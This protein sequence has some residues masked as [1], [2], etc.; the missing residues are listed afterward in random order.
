MR[1]RQLFHRFVFVALLAAL[2]TG[3]VP[4][5]SGAQQ[6]AGR[7]SIVSTGGLDFERQ[8]VGTYGDFQTITIRNDNETGGPIV[9]SDLDLS[10]S[11][12]DDFLGSTNC[13]AGGGTLLVGQSCQIRI[14]FAPL[15]VGPRSV[16]L[17]INHAVL[18]SPVLLEGEGTAGYY[19]A[20]RAGQVGEFGDA[21]WYGDAA[22][23]RLNAPMIS[24]ATTANGGGYWLLGRDGGIFSYGNA[25]F[26]GSTGGMRLNKP[27]V[28]MA[29]T[30]TGKGYWLV[31]SDGGIFA[32]G[33]ARFF[34]S[35]GSLR[36]NKP[37]V[38]M[39]A[40][41]TGKGYWLVASDGGIFAFGD[42]RFFGSTGSIRLNKPINAMLARPD[43]KGYW[44]LASDGGIFAFGNARFFGAGAGFIF[45]GVFVGGAVTPDGRGYWLADNLG[46][47]LPF[48]N[49]S[50]DYGD[51][52]GYGVSDVIGIAG[53]APPLHPSLL[54]AAAK[55]ALPPLSPSITSMGQP[56]SVPLASLS[57]AGR[58][59]DAS[60]SARSTDGAS[61]TPWRSRGS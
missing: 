32:F 58:V 44:L 23:L 34:G 17:L 29:R 24:I 37:V 52:A 6:P 42:A 2:M 45:F 43:G 11:H 59:P 5:V 20:G 36:L 21:L 22:N 7:A 46:N 9:I 13:F 61:G 18:W 15:A 55:S 12:P 38:G 56:R 30:P 27:V 49:A 1:G 4:A 57:R 28:G 48:G 33:D 14:A 8:R 51:L 41:P 10:G 26:Y 60:T 47:V 50:R 31:A 40:T 54:A 35:T 16:W 39:A 19:L 3:G 25:K 53:T